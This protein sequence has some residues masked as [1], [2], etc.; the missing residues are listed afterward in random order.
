MTDD[1][2]KFL[3][4]FAVAMAAFSLI[5]ETG[6]RAWLYSR[7]VVNAAYPV[8]TVDYPYS[9]GPFFVNDEGPY[10]PNTHF[11]LREYGVDG[12]FQRSSQVSINNLGWVSSDD[13]LL[14]KPSGQFRLAIL[15]DSLTAS[16]NNNIPWPSVVQKELRKELPQAA[17]MNLGVPG[18]NTQL[19]AQL[20]LPIAQH[21]AADAIVVNLI[22]ENLDFP[23]VQKDDQVKTQA[24]PLVHTQMLLIGDVT[25][26]AFCFESKDDCQLNPTWN[27]P[28][29]RA[30]TQSEVTEVK[31]IAARLALRNRLLWAPKS[32]LFSTQG[33]MQ[34]A[35]TADPEEQIAAAIAALLEIK[36]A[37]PNLLV[38]INPLEWYY[39]PAT[40]PAKSA[41]FISDATTAGLD[42]IQMRGHL[43]EA[44]ADE[45][46]RWW[47]MSYDGHWSNYGAGIYGCAIADVVMTRLGGNSLQR[48]G[49]AKCET[50]H[51]C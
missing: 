16:I 15:G 41:K 28:R 9:P 6:Y 2:R 44:S 32:F 45:R 19:M 7:Y 34:S 49:M 40:M 11:A 37:Y 8:V 46:H 38:T 30:L 3:I 4:A 14:P 24:Q 10:P 25:V 12:T 1:P 22:I 27:V 47:N 18:M 20:T 5:G 35:P 13:F 51:P 23:L 42:V 50:T 48:A 39:N 29:G 43:P 26:P 21:L 36:K 33:V 31:Q 17:V